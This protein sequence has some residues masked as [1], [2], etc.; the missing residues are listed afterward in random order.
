MKQAVQFGDEN[1]QLKD[2]AMFHGLANIHH[3][4]G[5]LDAECSFDETVKP[6]I[7]ITGK[8]HCSTL[9]IPFEYEDVVATSKLGCFDK[10]DSGTIFIPKLNRSIAIVDVMFTESAEKTP[11]FN[12]TLTIVTSMLSKSLIRTTKLFVC[13]I[14]RNTKKIISICGTEKF[15]RL[16]DVVSIFECVK[17]FELTNIQYWD[18]YI[19]EVEPYRWSRNVLEYEFTNDA[20]SLQLYYDDGS[21][22]SIDGVESITS[23]TK[24]SESFF[25]IKFVKE[26]F[27]TKSAELPIKKCT[28]NLIELP[29]RDTN[30]F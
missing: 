8:H 23:I 19:I 6:A 10:C 26:D 13:L 20:K 30:N 15:V 12:T 22:S 25:V 9:K 28:N 5:T 24:N 14:N 27:M 7:D 3:M 11:L 2:V 29:V 18:A 17:G 21:R 1:A 16:T 4:S